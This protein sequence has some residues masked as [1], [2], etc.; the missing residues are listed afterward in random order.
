MMAGQPVLPG[1]EE[2]LAAGK[3][4]ASRS[5]IPRPDEVRALTV[6]YDL[7]SDPAI[8]G[9]LEVALDR[10]LYTTRLLSAL[11]LQTPKVLEIGA[12]PY[13][14]TVLL[15]KCLGYELTALTEPW[16]GRPEAGT[17]QIR[18][19]VTGELLEIPFVTA[20]IETDQL[21]LGTESFDLVIFC[22][23][24]EHLTHDPTWALVEIHRVLKR[25]GLLLVSTPNALRWEYLRRM[26]KGTNYYPPYS[27][28]GT[29]ARHNREFST[30]ELRELLEGCGFSLKSIETVRDAAYD[31]PRL[32]DRAATV[33]TKFGLWRDRLDVI[34]ALAQRGDTSRLCYPEH[35]YYDIH[36]YRRI[37]DPFVRMGVNDQLQIDHSGFYPLEDWPPKIRWTKRKANVFLRGSGQSSLTIRFFSGERAGNVRGSIAAAGDLIAEFDAPAGVWFE[38]EFA[39]Q[40]AVQGEI[41]V[42]VS[43]SDPWVPHRLSGNGD[44]RELGV[45]L[46]RLELC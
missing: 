1:A 28:Y 2:D 10:L 7:L 29:T 19:L 45:A 37:T 12:R 24:I 41:E 25:G 30:S 23:V 32:W 15:K 43:V 40:R 27:G 38:Q 22:E 9:Y 26:L 21:P 13:L 34:H 46:E 42:S 8:Q 31:H 17:E 14:M 18:N 33:F 36:G 4:N 44:T 35:L 5:M 16:A 6:E 11:S 39:M 3:R 20:N